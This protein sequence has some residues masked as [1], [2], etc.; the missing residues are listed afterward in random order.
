[1]RKAMNGKA[2][3]LKLPHVLRV[4]RNLYGYD[5]VCPRMVVGTPNLAEC[6]TPYA[7]Y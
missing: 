5:A 2:L 6:T 7:V 3:Y 4:I 1:M